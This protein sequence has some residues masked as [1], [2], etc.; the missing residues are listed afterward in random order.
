MA[1]Q[2]TI[3]YV[4]VHVGGQLF[5]VEVS[6]VREVFSPQGITSVPRAP[7]E[8]AGLLNLRGRIVTAVETRQRLGL[9]PRSEGEPVMA[10][11]LE[12]GAE[13][14]G[15][16]VD[17]VGEVLRLDPAEMEPA[18]GHLDTQWRAM[19][20]GVYRLEERLMAVL[21]VRALIRWRSALA[22]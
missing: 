10:L 8:I 16:L 6:E 9:P 2:D 14:F 5:G 4:T 3:E 1:V 20:K 17:E 19:I 21:D 22:A 15:V 18:P 13:L 7:G 11:G 12:E